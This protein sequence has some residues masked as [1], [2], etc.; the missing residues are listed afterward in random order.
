MS[1]SGPTFLLR[2]ALG[3]LGNFSAPRPSLPAREKGKAF[4]I[5][6][7]LFFAL[8]P[9]VL[10]GVS[11]SSEPPVT[12]PQEDN[13]EDRG[14][15]YYAGLTKSNGDGTIT[16]EIAAAD[17]APPA[18]S[19]ANQWRIKLSK[20]GAPLVGAAVVGALYMNDHGHGGPPAISSEIGDGAYD[21][22]PLKLRMAGLWQ[23]TLKIQPQGESESTVV[24]NI[25][26]PRD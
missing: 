21:L 15:T 4:M 8:L 23:V 2:R 18:N 10:A 25:C 24:F 13:C 14:D 17:P 6:K 16:A 7:R 19:N 22:G 5:S 3:D 9:S 1:P 11:C 20:G 12:S 26:I